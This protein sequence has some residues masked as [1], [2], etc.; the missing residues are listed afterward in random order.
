M[1]CG[2]KWD[3]FGGKLG[4]K[5]EPSLGRGVDFGRR[6]AKGDCLGKF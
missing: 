5:A 4:E 1:K 3:I 6:Q 2:E